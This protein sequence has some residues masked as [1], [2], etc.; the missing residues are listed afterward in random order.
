MHRKR[1]H[2]FDFCL[3]ASLRGSSIF[4]LHSSSPQSIP[5]PHA[6]NIDERLWILTEMKTSTTTQ[7]L[8]WSHILWR[9]KLGHVIYVCKLHVSYVC[10]LHV[11]Y[12]CDR[13]MWG[14]YYVHKDCR[15]NRS[16][17]FEENR[18]K[19]RFPLLL[20]SL[21]KSQISSLVRSK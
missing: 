9:Q 7:P 20:H 16:K 14:T 3:N 19:S 10:K 11:S 15:I 1:Y 21:H 13:T 4:L 18:V 2:D 6:W 8:V 12:V 5:F 17:V